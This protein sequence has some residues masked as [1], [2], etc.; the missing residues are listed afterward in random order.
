[1]LLSDCGE[2][3]HSH[4]RTGDTGTTGWRPRPKPRGRMNDA[5]GRMAYGGRKKIP[6]TQRDST[7]SGA[8]NNHPSDVFV[9][10]LQGCRLLLGSVPA[11]AATAQPAGAEQTRLPGKF[12]LAGGDLFQGPS[13]QG[14]NVVPYL[15]DPAH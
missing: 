12:A 1:M 13:G 10:S 14:N 5:Q 9:R 3:S 4:A 2:E 11:R 7:K 6:K 8:G 15:N